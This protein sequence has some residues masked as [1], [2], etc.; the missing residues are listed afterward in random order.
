MFELS[1]N[2]WIV[3]IFGWIISWLI[4]YLITWYFFSKKEN[5]EYSQKTRTANNE[6]LY[7]IRPLIAQWQIPSNLILI[8]IIESI[9]RKYEIN[10]DH[11]LS[12]N[13]LTDDL[14]REVMENSFL[15]S[16]KKIE[17]CTKINDLR[18]VNNSPKK[19][20]ERIVERVVF[21]KDRLSY[22]YLS[23]LLAWIA[24]LTVFIPSVFITFK[25]ESL[26]I[27]VTSNMRITDLFTM[28][29]VGILIPFVMLLTVS[30]IKKL[31]D[32]R[33]KEDD[34]LEDQMNNFLK[35]QKR[36]KLD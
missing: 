22:Q 9:A 16:E 4:V 19:D 10:K 11:L 18:L 5:R 13:L 20:G 29:T 30:L 7:T 26:L 1:D 31:R 12:V 34:I 24:S 23:I 3:G 14:I 8:S 35:R 32:L 15:S 2:P 36:E 6:L 25:W 17:F 28:M 21:Q 33:Y 27:P